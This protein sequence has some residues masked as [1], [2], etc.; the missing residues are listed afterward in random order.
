MAFINYAH[1][2]KRCRTS[3]M[4]HDDAEKKTADDRE[5]HYGAWR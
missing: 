4:N 5:V 1:K 3:A 2:D